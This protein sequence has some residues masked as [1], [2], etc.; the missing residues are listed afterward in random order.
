MDLLSY[1]IKVLYR[2]LKIF[3]VAFFNAFFLS[4]LYLYHVF[5]LLLS[6]MSWIC[7]KGQSNEP[8][9]DTRK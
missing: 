4:P 3:I 5:P 2:H 1:T 6:F 7:M 9:F 8:W